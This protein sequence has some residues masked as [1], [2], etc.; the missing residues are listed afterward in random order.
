MSAEE[1]GLH[2][3]L[4]DARN[5]TYA[6]SDG[7][8]SDITASIWRSDLGKGRAFDFLS[9]EGGELLL[10]DQA[11]LQAIHTFLWKLRLHV[12]KAVQH[13]PAPRDALPVLLIDV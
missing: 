2:E 3:M 5:R 6:H 4:I 13:H 11:Q 10:F 1:N 7:D 9:V 8:H 12:D